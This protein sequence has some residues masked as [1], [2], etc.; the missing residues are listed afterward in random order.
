MTDNSTFRELI[1]ESAQE[2]TSK[3]E[4]SEKDTDI[5]ESAEKVEQPEKSEQ[6]EKV[7]SFTDP[8]DEKSLQEMSPA[9][10]LELRKNWEAAYTKKRQAETQ[11]LKELREKALQYEQQLAQRQQV[12]EQKKE[13]AA[14]Q[15]SLGNMTPEQYVE[16]IRQEAIKDAIAA[17]REE[18]QKAVVEREEQSLA[19]QAMSEFTSTDERLDP[20]NPNHDEVF[21]REVTREIAELLDKH[22]EETGSYRGFD[23]KALTK[24]IVNRRDK[25]IDDIVRKRTEAS[26]KTA[27]MRDA[28]LKK[29][30]VR[31][32][33]SDSKKIGG[34]SF[35]DILLETVDAAA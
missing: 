29:S 30:E 9:K 16:F 21:T 6:P 2:V 13:Q 4:V 20:N 22:L 35:R 1:E 27:K 8:V 28:K 11:E 24:E 12:S 32:T 10:L 23:T 17:A 5:T 3:E 15:V 26:I 19:Q 25:E 31:G 7:E 14:E 33:T 34:E 18:T